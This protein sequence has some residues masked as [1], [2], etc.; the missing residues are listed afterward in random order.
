[1]NRIFLQAVNISV[2]AGY[3]SLAILLIRKVFTRSPKWLNV[4]LWSLVA[5]RLMIPFSIESEISL[6]PSGETFEMNLLDEGN[7]DYYINTGI[8]II[9]EPLNEYMGDKYFEGVTVRYNFKNDLTEFLAKVWIAGII[10]MLIY[11][12]VSY[13]RLKSML[14]YA[15]KYED[16]IFMSEFV[17]SPFVL[18]LISP[19]IYIPYDISEKQMKFVISHEKTHIKRF[20]HFT[21]IFAYILL[22]VYWFNPVLW[23]SYKTFCEDL[24]MACDEAV[25]KDLG[26]S[27]KQAYSAALLGF[28]M[29][30][31]SFSACPLAFG[32][33]GLK[34]RIKSIMNY[35]KPTK[36]I[37]ILSV[38]LI[39]LFTIFFMTVPPSMGLEDIDVWTENIYENVE[40]IYAVTPDSEYLLSDEVSVKNAVEALK[41]IELNS[42]EVS[43]NRSEDRPRDYMIDIGHE[44]ICFDETLT[45]VW[46][47]NSVKPSLTYRIKNP[48]YVKDTFFSDFFPGAV[49][50]NRLKGEIITD[51]F[52]GTVRRFEVRNTLGEYFGI[53]ITPDTILEFS[54]KGD[55]FIINDITG[56]IP[57]DGISSGAYVSIESAGE[58]DV[59]YKEM[60]EWIDASEYYIAKKITVTGFDKN[61]FLADGEQKEGCFYTAFLLLRDP[62]FFHCPLFKSVYEKI[63]SSCKY[64]KDYY[65]RHYK[66]QIENLRAVHDKITYACFADEEFSHYYADP[67]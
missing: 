42:H 16:N 49:I 63:H 3:L 43:Q 11:A 39:I 28:G 19:K 12:A 23:I 7:A 10:I 59:S 4:I 29:K 45:H 5:I 37:I 30:R 14:L 47:D 18:G 38:V 6:V 58:N 67:A 54:D 41:K 50:G 15:T 64:A 35:K 31:S 56:G 65:S 27:E 20:D 21:K 61:Y 34:E 1:M 26:Y 24:E 40:Y 25:I 66:I 60:Y 2:T 52:D 62:A 55:E 36:K 22:S 13:V 32:E 57:W 53:I 44:T 51:F 8:D 33:V 48:E 17:K 9:D 46:L